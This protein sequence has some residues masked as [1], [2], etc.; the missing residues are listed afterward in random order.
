MPLLV[1]ATKDEVDVTVSSSDESSSSSS[2]LY[3]SDSDACTSST[4]SSSTDK[5]KRVQF[6]EPQHADCHASPWSIQKSDGAYYPPY[7]SDD[8]GDENECSSDTIMVVNQHQVWYTKTDI[9]KFKS[10]AVVCARILTRREKQQQQ[11]VV[12]GSCAW[13]ADLAATFGHFQ[14]VDNLQAMN[15]VMV[16]VADKPAMDADY[17]GLDKFWGNTATQRSKARKHMFAAVMELQSRQSHSASTSKALRKISRDASRTSRLYAIYVA[18][19]V[20]KET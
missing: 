6:K 20:A 4:T 12:G 14:T 13:A 11:A 2:P 16:T 8:L 9:G 17:V 10:D 1:K 19:V 3:C 5:C 15:A 18:R 7:S